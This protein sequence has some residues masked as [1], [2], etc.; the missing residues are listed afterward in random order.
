[1]GQ[2]VTE[3]AGRRWPAF[4]L[5]A[6]TQFVVVLDITIVNVA[7]PSIE[8]SLGFSREGL[9]CRAVRWRRSTWLTTKAADLEE[10]RGQKPGGGDDE[11]PALF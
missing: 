4:A 11:P 7:L 1:V 10:L 5:L 8:T 6:M 2:L 3:P 9:A